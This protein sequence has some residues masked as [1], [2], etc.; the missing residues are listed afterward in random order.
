MLGLKLGYDGTSDT[1]FNYCMKIC[2][3][4]FHKVLKLKSITDKSTRK[5]FTFCTLHLYQQHKLHKL[6]MT[7]TR[8]VRND[9]GCKV[10]CKSILSEFYFLNAKQLTDMAASKFIKGIIDNHEPSSIYNQI[11][12]PTRTCAIT[13]LK[14]N[15]SKK[16]RFTICGTEP[17]GPWHGNGQGPSQPKGRKHYE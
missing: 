10:S 2:W 17:K 15:S 3:A 13:T 9:Y 1:N 11:K 7:C 5:I 6:I 14:L 16:F 12:I 4:S 8:Y